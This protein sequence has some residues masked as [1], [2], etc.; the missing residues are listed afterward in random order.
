V[1]ALKPG[2]TLCRADLLPLPRIKPWFLGRPASIPVTMP[3]THINMLTQ[4]CFKG[5]RKTKNTSEEKV[6]G[7]EVRTL[8]LQIQKTG[9]NN[10][11]ASCYFNL[12]LRNRQRE[13]T[14]LGFA[15]AGPIRDINQLVPRHR[16]HTTGQCSKGAKERF[17][18]QNRQ[19]GKRRRKLFAVVCILKQNLTRT[20]YENR[21]HE[22]T[23]TTRHVHPLRSNGWACIITYQICT[24]SL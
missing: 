17:L 12:P 20:A 10:H 8:D 24:Y 3:N 5:L 16:L 18:R 7:A 23:L 9:V 21:Q 13:G 1:S 6:Y 15:E 19:H 11:S 14:A 4:A 22:T 2:W